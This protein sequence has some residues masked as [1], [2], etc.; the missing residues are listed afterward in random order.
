MRLLPNL[1]ECMAVAFG[2]LEFDRAVPQLGEGGPCRN[3]AP[4]GYMHN[5]GSERKNSKL[6][7]IV[8]RKS[9]LGGLVRFP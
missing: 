6:S 1:R 5:K 7:G 9:Q 8:T 3:K 4:V 2:P